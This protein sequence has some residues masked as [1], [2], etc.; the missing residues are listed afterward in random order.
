MARVS[1]SGGASMD[2]EEVMQ[3]AQ[4]NPDLFQ[5]VL[6][7]FNL[8]G[9]ADAP[10]ARQ[11]AVTGDV[12]MVDVTTGAVGGGAPGT[13]MGSAGGRSAATGGGGTR[14]GFGDATRQGTPITGTGAAGGGGGGGRP[15][16][17][18]TAAPAPGGAPG[19]GGMPGSQYLAGKAAQAGGYR[20]LAGSAAKKGLTLAGR[21]APLVGGGIQLLQGDPLGAVGSVAGGMLGGL[22][23][24]VGSI[25]GATIGGPVVKALA[26]GASNLVSAATGAK[27]EAGES[28]LLGGPIQGLSPKELEIAELLRK[29]EVKTSAEML[30]I[31]KQYRDVERQNTMQLN[32]Q[33]GQLTGAL[34]RQMY[35]AQLAGGAQQQAG[36][37][38]RGIIGG[39][40]PYAASVFRG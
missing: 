7:Y 35:A 26:G 18:G 6:N 34:N 1:T 37:T 17:T 40:N 30:P 10:Q 9:G 13:A 29:G 27:R 19:G 11:S 25:A 28:G 20:A 32:Q 24:P 8:G 2:P 16:V 12:G 33:V 14:T 15:P 4:T 5:K 22:L 39:S 36:Q 23:G 38:V 21:Y 3:L 31:F